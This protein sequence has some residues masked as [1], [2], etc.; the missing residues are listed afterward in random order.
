MTIEVKR[1]P[2]KVCWWV[3]VNGIFLN[4]HERKYQAEREASYLRRRY[5]IA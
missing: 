1:S 4:A 2:A 5:A 3:I